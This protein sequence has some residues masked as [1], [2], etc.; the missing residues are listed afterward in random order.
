MIRPPPHLTLHPR[1]QASGRPRS[2]PRST[3]AGLCVAVAALA[4]TSPACAQD[5]VIDKGDV[6]QLSVVGMPTLSARVPVGLDGSASFPLLGP[7][8]ARGKTLSELRKTIEALLP[9]KAL[10]TLGADGRELVAS[11]HGDAIT[12][13]VAD[14]R[15]IYVRGDV[16]KSGE[17][18][19]RPGMTVRQ[20]ISVAGGY[21]LVR[22]R[23]TNPFLEAAD[24][25]SESEVLWLEF[26]K[27]QIR[28]WSVE[29]ELKGRT[30]LQRVELPNAPV[31][32]A[33]MAQLTK[34]ADEKLALLKTIQQRDKT[35]LHTVIRQASE[36]IQFLDEQSKR[37]QE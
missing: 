4:W 32:A 35:L 18:P 1:R 17:Q 36:Q 28:L 37:Q 33:L 20:A 7:V 24:L 2:R 10:R 29:A 27:E 13:D 22:F 8:P 26:V 14:Y 19:F 12:L 11:V 23:M 3:L 30:S 9:Q 21:D 34:T 25:R 15:P 6:L 16:T 31:P 5:Y